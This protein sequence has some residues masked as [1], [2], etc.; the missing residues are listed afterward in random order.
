MLPKIAE[1]TDLTVNGRVYPAI[2]AGEGPLAV[3]LHGF[4]D[5]YE[6]FQHQIDPFVAA[7]YR[8]VC[9]MMPGF[10]PGT[11]PSSG[12]NTP[13]YAVDEMIAGL[14]TALTIAATFWR[15]PEMSEWASYATAGVAT[16][17]SGACPFPWTNGLPCEWGSSQRFATDDPCFSYDYVR[18]GMSTTPARNYHEA[19]QVVTDW[20]VEIGYK[21]TLRHGSG[22]TADRCAQ[23][24]PA[25]SREEALSGSCPDSC[26]RYSRTRLRA[27]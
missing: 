2:E 18:H 22:L 1:K 5:N 25:Q 9:P 24:L 27:Q 4:P 16:G 14:S 6:S 19:C 21:T 13:V 8:I 15:R 12:S 23:V 10:A 17:G 7:G 11:Q 3:C 20:A 26:V